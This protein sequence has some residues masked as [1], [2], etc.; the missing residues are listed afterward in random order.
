MPSQQRKYIFK[1]CRGWGWNSLVVLWL[2][3]SV[4]SAMGPGSVYEQSVEGEHFTYSP[5]ASVLV[6]SLCAH[7]YAYKFVCVIFYLVGFTSVLTDQK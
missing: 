1:K 4:F 2:G 5:Q 6:L 3:L 7:I